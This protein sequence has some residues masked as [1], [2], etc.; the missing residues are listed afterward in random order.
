MPTGDKDSARATQIPIRSGKKI[1]LGL[2]QHLVQIDGLGDVVVHACVAAARDVLHQQQRRA[3]DQPGGAQDALVC[4]AE[5]AFGVAV[6]KADETLKRVL[7]GDGHRQH[8]RMPSGES[9]FCS[10]CD[11]LRTMLLMQRLPRSSA[12]ISNSQVPCAIV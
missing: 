8:D 7:Y 11:M 6:V 2:A 9:W 12:S 1:V 10:A 5:K 3:N 4:F